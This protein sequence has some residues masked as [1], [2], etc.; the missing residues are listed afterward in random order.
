MTERRPPM[1]EAELK[2]ELE[3][4]SERADT[5][6]PTLWKAALDETKTNTQTGTRHPGGRRLRLPGTPR[7]QR[8]AVGIAALLA[9][10]VSFSLLLDDGRD[11]T[12]EIG[13]AGDSVSSATPDGNLAP[14]RIASTPEETG[15]QLEAL[16]GRKAVQGFLSLDSAESLPQDRAAFGSGGARPRSLSR[17][18]EGPGD[19]S[20]AGRGGGSRRSRI[21]G[22]A[23]AGGRVPDPT[24]ELAESAAADIADTADRNDTSLGTAEPAPAAPKSPPPTP[25]LRLLEK[26]G[27]LGLIADDVDNAAEAIERLI[28][29]SAGEFVLASKIEGEDNRRRAG[30]SLTIAASRFDRVVEDLGSIAEVVTR[31]LT[32]RDLS[33]EAESLDAQIAS[34][35]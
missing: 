2:R 9:I 4:M 28:E 32:A 22:A 24:P 20:E 21:P 23:A 31:E 6:E 1:T 8:A 35:L 18:L 17:T 7:L 14:F 13:S 29:P 27:D 34:A 10:A 19:Q 12:I 11:R 16:L 26:R 33:L 5:H 25:V 15:R 30:V 3:A